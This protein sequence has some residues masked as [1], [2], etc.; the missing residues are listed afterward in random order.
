MKEFNY[1]NLNPLKIHTGDC[2]VRAFAFFFGIPWESAFKVLTNHC[3]KQGKVIF[4]YVSNFGGYLKSQGIEKEKPK[5]KITVGEFC[6][7]V[8]K[9]GYVYIVRVKSHL[10]IVSDK[11]V[12]DTWDCRDKEVICYWGRKK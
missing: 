1:I 11:D 3:A 9:D 7:K 8:A 6:E 4:N 10:T 5:E 12:F 2:V